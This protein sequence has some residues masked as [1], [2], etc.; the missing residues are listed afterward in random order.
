VGDLS[1]IV[2]QMAAVGVG[3]ALLVYALL[4]LVWMG[5]T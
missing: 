2:I 3:L 1:K 4:I 5:P